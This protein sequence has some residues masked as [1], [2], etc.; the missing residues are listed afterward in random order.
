[1]RLLSY[2]SFNVYLPF[3]APWNLLPRAA[4]PIPQQFRPGSLLCLHGQVQEYELDGAIQFVCGLDPEKW[5]SCSFC[6]RNQQGNTVCHENST[7]HYKLCNSRTLSL[8]IM[9]RR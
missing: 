2:K 3:A 7:E 9:Q 4:T 1:M 8:D 6:V 5:C